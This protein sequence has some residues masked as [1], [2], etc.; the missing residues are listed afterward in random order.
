MTVQMYYPLPLVE[1]NIRIYAKMFGNSG[2][3]ILR[4]QV[5][6]ASFTP[7]FENWSIFRPFSLLNLVSLSFFGQVEEFEMQECRTEGNLLMYMA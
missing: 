1:I 2:I 3:K 5:A 7:F 6:A 4:G